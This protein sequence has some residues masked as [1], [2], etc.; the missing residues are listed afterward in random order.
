MWDK[1]PWYS[2]IVCCSLLLAASSG[3]WGRS[4]PATSDPTLAD[5]QRWGAMQHGYVTD[6]CWHG[7]SATLNV[8]IA[9]CRAFVLDQTDPEKLVGFEELQPST[10]NYPPGDGTYW[11]GGR[12]NPSAP[13][14][15]WTC[16]SGLHYCLSAASAAAPAVPSGM[17]LLGKT[18]V[19]GGAITAFTIRAPWRRT[20]PVPVALG[21]TLTFEACPEAG[22]WQ[23]FQADE[24][25]T[26]AVRFGQETCSVVYPEWFGVTADGVT[27]NFLALKATIYA[28]QGI[29]IALSSGTIKYSQ[30]LEVSGVDVRLHGQGPGKTLLDATAVTTSRALQVLGA[31]AATTTLA[32]ADLAWRLTVTVASGR[33]DHAAE[34]GL[35]DGA[36][37]AQLWN[38]S[39]TAP[40]RSTTRASSSRWRVG[41]G[42]VLTLAH[43]LEDDYLDTTVVRLLDP[44]AVELRDLELV[45]DAQ[46]KG[47]RIENALHPIIDNVF[48]HGFRESALD[49]TNVVEGSIT[50]YRVQDVNVSGTTTSYGFVGVR[51]HDFTMTNCHLVAG[52]H[53][54]TVGVGSGATGIT[55][56][57]NRY[58]RVTNNYFGGEHA[59]STAAFD[60]HSNAEYLTLARQPYRGV[61]PGGR[62][63]SHSPQYDPQCPGHRHGGEYD[64]R[65][66]DLAQRFGHAGLGLRDR[67]QYLHARRN[68]HGGRGGASLHLCHRRPDQRARG[69]FHLPQQCGHHR[70]GRRVPHRA[71]PVS[72]SHQ[73][74][75]RRQLCGV[76]RQSAAQ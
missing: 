23:I 51:L 55:S 35:L 68:L 29:P 50:R 30:P 13:M 52:R 38:P 9:S 54:F 41:A 65:A 1:L 5:Q 59:V 37:P 47:V 42:T 2:I 25:T 28:A 27:E 22:R 16:Q 74:R 72:L 18:T 62:E 12:A 73:Y 53:A 39:V 14:T 6:G 46:M 11:L 24:V 36:T 67:A 34:V 33:R 26:G 3:A 69:V 45:G 66:H 48:L 44:V 8:N 56:G 49:F 20:T 63:A 43:R 21:T 40:A 19:A 64:R 76:L 32:G 71:V 10:L 31:L 57:V 7:P 58:M 4:F 61:G 17:L 70:G 60:L 15:G 75:R